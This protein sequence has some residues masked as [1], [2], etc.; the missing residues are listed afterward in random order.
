MPSTIYDLA[1]YVTT[2][3]TY[4]HLPVSIRLIAKTN[5]YAALVGY[6]DMNPSCHVTLVCSRSTGF[7][8]GPH[9]DAA[10]AIL[11]LN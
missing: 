10:T 8:P 9:G 5:Q 4:I 7:P 1:I 11:V 2:Y 3:I 6:L